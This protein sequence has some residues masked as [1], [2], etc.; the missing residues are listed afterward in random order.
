MC[1]VRTDKRHADTKDERVL[2]ADGGNLCTKGE[3]YT[4]TTSLENH[5]RQALGY[6][7]VHA[8]PRGDD[9]KP[10]QTIVRESFGLSRKTSTRKPNKLISTR[11]A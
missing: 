7:P 2:G 10:K 6:V 9:Q 5:S 3:P 8:G 11:T 1:G 4:V